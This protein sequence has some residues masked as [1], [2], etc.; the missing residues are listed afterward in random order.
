LQASKTHQVSTLSLHGHAQQHVATG[1]DE[2]LIDF[3]PIF[4]RNFC[5]RH[6]KKEASTK[7]RKKYFLEYF[8][9]AS[10]YPTLQLI[11]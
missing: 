9:N 11:K 10:R 2:F 7:E 8:L 1:T 5:S 3:L 4:I 6:D